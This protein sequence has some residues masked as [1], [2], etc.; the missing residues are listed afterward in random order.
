MRVIRE[1]QNTMTT[2]QFSILSCL[3]TSKKTI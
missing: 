3:E 1:N 2:P